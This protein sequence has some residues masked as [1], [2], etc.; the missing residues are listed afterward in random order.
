MQELREL[1][2][3]LGF[4]VV[5]TFTQK[6]ASFDTTAY[7]CVGKRQEMRRFVENEAALDDGEASPSV[8]GNA[9][10]AAKSGAAI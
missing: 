8:P 3:T 10:R 5:R 1:A 4:E 9:H 2:K 7:L 6:R